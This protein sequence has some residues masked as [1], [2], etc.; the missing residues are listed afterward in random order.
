[1]RTL[2]IIALWFNA[3][4]APAQEAAPP[5]HS[6]A[7]QTV[8]LGGLSL[9]VMGLLWSLPAEQSQWYDKPPESPRG[10]HDRWRQNVKS[11]PV[12]DGDM[13]FFNGY[14]H[15]HSG[16]A[17]T[18]L[19][20]E[21]GAS[22]TLCTIYANAVSLSWEFGP[23]AVVEKPS[24]QDILMTGMVGSRVGLQ[25]H[26]WKRGIRSSG[27]QVLGSTILGRTAEFLLDPFGV[28][29]NGI[30]SVGGGSS[31]QSAAVPLVEPGRLGYLW[32]LTF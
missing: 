7:A 29:I 3:L 11:G 6:L 23:E 19:C 4:P 16:A 15:I 32:T 18:V 12:W 25:F 2:L 28:T 22:A 13:R 17:Y 24:Y 21:A 30:L 9:G 20:L 5:E 14:G 10:L 1:M 27:H 26:R 31:V 8:V